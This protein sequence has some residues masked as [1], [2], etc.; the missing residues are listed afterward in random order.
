MPSTDNAGLSEKSSR[1]GPLSLFCVALYFFNSTEVI[2]PPPRRHGHIHGIIGKNDCFLLFEVSIVMHSGA[3]RSD[4]ALASYNSRDGSG[5]GTAGFSDVGPDTT[6]TP[7]VETLVL[8]AC[9]LA[10]AGGVR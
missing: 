2:A 4:L 10:G 1:T 3:R 9:G 6:A 8:D 7:F 5:V